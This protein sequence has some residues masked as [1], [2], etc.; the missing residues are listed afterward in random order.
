[1]VDHEAMGVE[2]LPR[3]TWLATRGTRWLGALILFI[4]LVVNLVVW[5]VPTDRLSGAR[6]IA[7]FVT[8]GVVAL[9]VLVWRL[10]F[11]PRLELFS[12][13]LEVVNPFSTRDVPLTEIVAVAPSSMGL[14][15]HLADGGT[16]TAWA[17]QAASE[18]TPRVRAAITELRSAIAAAQSDNPEESP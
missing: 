11:V 9:A 1:M 2:V 5:T 17:L 3:E 8:V 7:P 16:V 4:W 10:A 14:R 15:I 18:G 12:D 13:R 6:S